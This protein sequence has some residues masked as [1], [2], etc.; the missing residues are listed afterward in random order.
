V[1]VKTSFD[2]DVLDGIVVGM[3][4]L[5]DDVFILSALLPSR[6]CLEISVTWYCLNSCIDR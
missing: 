6:V 1:S 4:D 5:S 3:Y 2:V